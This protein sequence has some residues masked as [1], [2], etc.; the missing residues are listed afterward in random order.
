MPEVSVIIPTYNRA[1]LLP[2]TIGSVLGQSYQDFE[3]IVVD[4]A[5]TD[6]IQEVINKFRDERIGYIR[7]AEN[8]GWSSKPRNAGLLG[9]RGKYI[10]FLDS[11]DEWLPSLLARLVEKIKQTSVGLVYCGLV[12]ESLNGR[13]PYI[14]HSR[15]R[16]WVWPN[17]LEVCISSTTSSL[18]KRECFDK[19]GVF[20]DSDCRYDHWDMWIRLSKK[21]EF[22][23][24][25]EA[26]ARYNSHINQRS[27]ANEAWRMKAILEKY[28][29]DYAWYPVQAGV[30]RLR[31]GLV[32]AKEGN[33]REALKYII[34]NLRYGWRVF[35]DL[36]RTH[37]MPSGDN[38]L[39]VLSTL[40]ETIFNKRL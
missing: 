39:P 13:R 20:D 11:D 12:M 7:L 26:L 32:Y 25:P 19:V 22:D 21:Y 2:R 17:T 8:S 40:L 30:A 9:A 35:A 16:G 1:H 37:R 24:V 18:I 15:Q 4:D 5:S 36:R 14:M 23:Y 3:I 10:A 31:L 34:P 33:R 29:E 28:G 27:R 38:S 6:N